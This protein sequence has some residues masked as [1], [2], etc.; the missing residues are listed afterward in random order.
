[1]TINDVVTSSDKQARLIEL[2]RADPSFTAAFSGKE[3]LKTD[4]DGV[5]RGEQYNI[6]LEIAGS[7]LG[8]GSLGGSG[9][10]TDCPFSQLVLMVYVISESGADADRK[11]QCVRAT[12]QILAIMRKYQAHSRQG[13]QIWYS[14]EMPLRQGGLSTTYHWRKEEGIYLSVTPI[15]LYSRATILS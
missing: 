4:P 15:N 1:M 8:D 3:I 13:K 7:G 9:V 12:E 5:T 6:T 11:Q 2:L 14:M 10:G